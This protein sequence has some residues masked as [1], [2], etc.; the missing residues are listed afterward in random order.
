MIFKSLIELYINNTETN[1]IEM[2]DG[3][4]SVKDGKQECGKWPRRVKVVLEI[5]SEN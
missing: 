1:N 5:S 3:G 4:N 2:G